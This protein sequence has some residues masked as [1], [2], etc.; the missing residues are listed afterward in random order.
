MNIL[1]FESNYNF[2]Q[3]YHTNSVNR[4]IHIICIPMIVWTASVMLVNVNV[5]KSLNLSKCLLTFYSLYYLLFSFKLGVGMTFLLYLVYKNSIKY[6][7]LKVPFI[8]AFLLH[9][10]AWVLQILGHSLFENNRPAFMDNLVQSF[11]MAPIFVL[12]EVL[13]F[14]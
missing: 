2:Y 13:Y 7:G 14:L 5:S 11:L 1:D 3:K 6:K 9:I 12:K 8:M 4:L 10:V